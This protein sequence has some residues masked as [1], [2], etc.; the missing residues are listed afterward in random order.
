MYFL[1]LSNSPKSIQHHRPNKP[2]YAIH[3]HSTHTQNYQSTSPP[4]LPFPLPP[5]RTLS[6]WA[7]L[8]LCH[9]ISMLH[10]L[11]KLSLGI[12]LAYQPSPHP[13][14][15]PES[16]TQHAPQWRHH[17][18][19]PRCRLTPPLVLSPSTRSMFLHPCRAAPCTNRA[20]PQWKQY[21]RLA[22]FRV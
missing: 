10:H 5:C 14:W 12:L 9:I 20:S 16:R 4:P 6:I 1:T 18:V 3:D 19:G 2:Y 17:H 8:Y 13:Q 7:F 22:K 21:S 11:P 15:V